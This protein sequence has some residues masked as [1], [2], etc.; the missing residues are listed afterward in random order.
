ML[1][2]KIN[3]FTLFS[4][5]FMVLIF[6]L[7]FVH[8]FI[9]FLFV[10]FLK[11]LSLK[12]ISTNFVVS[13]E[14]KK[15]ENLFYQSIFFSFEQS[16]CRDKLERLDL[17]KLIVP[18]MHETSLCYDMTAS[19]VLD[20]TFIDLSRFWGDLTCYMKCILDKLK[21]HSN[22]YLKFCYLTWYVT[23]HEL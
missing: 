20:V 16:I 21:V 10:H 3:I 11:I 5:C 23:L 6:F 4:F 14:K 8:N 15:R 12:W 7:F 17:T 13:L 19:Y 9:F 18:N 2:Y 1:Q 22:V